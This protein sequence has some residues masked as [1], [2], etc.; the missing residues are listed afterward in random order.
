MLIMRKRKRKERKM[1]KHDIIN[2]IAVSKVVEEIIFNITHTYIDD[3]TQDIYL[4]LLEKDDDLIIQ[5]YEDEQLNYYITRM[6]LNNIRS[7]T[8]PYYYTYLKNKEREV[9]ID[10]IEGK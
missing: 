6:I 2:E 3:L 1:N 10:D 7:T 5:L 4:S 9:N 8:S